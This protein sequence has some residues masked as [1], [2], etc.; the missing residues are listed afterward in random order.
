MEGKA[1]FILIVIGLVIC[2]LL[3]HLYFTGNNHTTYDSKVS[4]SK[5]DKLNEKLD[6]TYAVLNHIRWI[7]LGLAGLFISTF[8][9]PHCS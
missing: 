7:G 8:I 5:D 9:L 1:I 3:L 2:F 6:K 4:V